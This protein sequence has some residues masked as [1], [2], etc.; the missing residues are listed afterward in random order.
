[1]RISGVTYTQVRV[2]GQMASFAIVIFDGYEK[3]QELKR[4]LGTHGDEIKTERGVWFG[5]NLDKDG[6]ARERA[7]GKVERALLL[8]REGRTD[9]YRDF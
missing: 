3:K 7:V 5:E 8:S 6:R 9:V 2:I 4:W 1:M